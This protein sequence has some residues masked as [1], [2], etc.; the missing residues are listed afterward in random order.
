[1]IFVKRVAG[2]SNSSCVRGFPGPNFFEDWMLIVKK[3]IIAAAVLCTLASGAA[4]A[5]QAQKTEGPWMVRAR[6]VYVDTVQLTRRA[7]QRRWI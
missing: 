1:L 2:G 4:L 7:W 3:H 5:Q 6:A